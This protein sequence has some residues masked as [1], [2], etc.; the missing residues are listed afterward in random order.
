VKFDFAGDLG[1][2]RLALGVQ[3]SGDL[4]PGSDATRGACSGTASTCYGPAADVTAAARAVT[5]AAPSVQ[6]PFSSLAGGMPVATVDRA[7]IVGIQW[8][9]TSPLAGGADGGA[10][11]AAAF[12]ASNVSF[13]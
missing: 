13:Y 2:C 6:V 1:G 12:T 7:N 4:Y 11:C 9:L 8:Q 10:A 5:A 3:F